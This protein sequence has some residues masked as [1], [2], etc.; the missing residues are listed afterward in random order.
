MTL[1]RFLQEKTVTRIGGKDAVPVDVRIIASAGPALENSVARGW[2][3]KTF[4][5]G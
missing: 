5:T 1:L 3:G 4:I 2:C